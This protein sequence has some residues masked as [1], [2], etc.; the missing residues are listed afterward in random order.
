MVIDR[1]RPSDRAEDPVWLD[2]YE[3]EQGVLKVRTMD[4]N[5]R[6]RLTSYKNAFSSLSGY[7]YVV[8]KM[9]LEHKGANDYH[10]IY[11]NEEA[12]DMYYFNG[13]GAGQIYYEQWVEFSFPISE[14]RE[15][16]FELRAYNDNYGSWANIYISDIRVTNER[17]ALIAE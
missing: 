13:G 15:G 17:P 3:G 12:G 7:Q 1:D 9:W 16:G 10:H 8:V 2:N 5:P 6:I 11:L 14:L 4:D